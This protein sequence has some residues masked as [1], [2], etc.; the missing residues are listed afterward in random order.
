MFFNLLK[1][2]RELK[3][4]NQFLEDHN[5]RLRIRNDDLELHNK[6]ADG[7]IDFWQDECDKAEQM[8]HD[9]AGIYNKRFGNE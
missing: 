5:K 6:W 8:L 7:E 9:I 2:N 1:E 4:R 3:E